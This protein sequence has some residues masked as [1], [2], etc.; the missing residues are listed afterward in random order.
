M[1]WSMGL[2]TCVA[3]NCLVWPQWER[4]HLYC[5]NLMLQRRRMQREVSGWAEEHPFR[6][7]GE[8]L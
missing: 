4:M 8:W 1:G 7:K 3:G 6:V 5:G 2:S